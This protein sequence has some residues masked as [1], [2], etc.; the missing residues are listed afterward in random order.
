[1]LLQFSDRTREGFEQSIDNGT[2][3]LYIH[4][5]GFVVVE[6]MVYLQE[7]GLGKLE[8]INN[9]HRDPSNDIKAKN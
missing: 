5:V 1:M 3:K 9:L 4:G 6:N 2:V 7:D 8:I